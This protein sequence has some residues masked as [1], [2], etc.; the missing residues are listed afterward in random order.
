[1]D[2]Y[3]ID[4]IQTALQAEALTFGDYTLK[5]GRNSPYFFSSSKFQ[6]GK[7][8]KAIGNVYAQKII[9]MG[10]EGRVIFGP[11]YKGCALSVAIPIALDNMGREV[12]FCHDRK[13][14]KDHGDGG[15]FCGREPNGNTIVVDDVITSGQSIYGAIDFVHKKGGKVTGVVVMLDRQERGD[16][17][18]LSAIQ[19]VEKNTGIMVHVIITLNDILEYVSSDPTYELH[20]DKIA[21][22]RKQYGVNG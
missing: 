1:M 3:K 7:H 6:S 20:A 16:K 17:S 11:A 4:F 14:V 8:L 13:I 2:Q 9:A 22:Y 21:E 12:D 15:D 18:D 10:I 5:S 19:E